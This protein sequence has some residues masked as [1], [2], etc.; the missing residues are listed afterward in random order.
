MTKLIL[1]RHG[2]SEWNEKNQFTGWVDAKLSKKGE[3]EAK[4]AGELI[5]DLNVNISNSYTSFL[6]RA[7]DTLSI[8]LRVIGDKNT[9]VKEAWELNERHYGSLTGLNKSETKAKLGE[10]VLNKYRR[11]WNLAPPPLEDNSIYLKRFSLLNKK[12]PTH[13]IPSTE[14]LKDTYNR[15]IPYYKEH[16]HPNIIKG[17]NILV[18]A[19]GNSLR[20]LCKYLFNIS[21]TKINILEIPTGNPLYIKF[22]SDYAKIIESLYLDKNRK[23]LLFHNE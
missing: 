19:H 8:V 1:I 11:S 2:Q 5:K 17:K 15:V 14:S 3:L 23:Q 10:K 4:L 9:G 20:A 6:K 18:V 22:S 7:T 12:I 16:I 13:K 21:D